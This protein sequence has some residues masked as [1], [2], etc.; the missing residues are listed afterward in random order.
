VAANGTINLDPIGWRGAKINASA[1]LEDSS[2][3]D[4]LTF[5]ARPFSAHND[6]HGEISLRYD[7]PNSN[8]AFGGGFNWSHVQPFVRL[9]ETSIDYEGPIYS[10]AFIEHKDVFGLT[11]N[12]NVFNLTD[13]RGLYHR[14]VH[15]GL[16]DR[17]PISFYEDRNLSIQPI[18]R[19][20]V[21]GSF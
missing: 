3:E 18:F 16:R 20:Q 5:V 17:T 8:W 7:V 21:K 4:P 13:G 12:L 9:A 19:L 6:W 2:L 14:I 11:V 1:T 15:T 10:F